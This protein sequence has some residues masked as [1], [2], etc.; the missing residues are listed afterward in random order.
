M[1][2]PAPLY[3]MPTVTD[4][5]DINIHDTIIENE[6]T[7]TATA[8]YNQI[9]RTITTFLLPL[10]LQPTVGFG[11]SKNV[12]PH[13]PIYHQL[14][15]SSHFQLLKISFYFLFPS[16]PGPSPSSR[17]FQFLSEDLFGHPI[18]LHSLQMTL[19]T[20][21]FPVIHF[22]VFYSSSSRFVLLFHSPFSYLA[23]YILL[24]IFV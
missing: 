6:I 19:S 1:L 10:A 4:N 17:P 24:N 8:I 20:Y 5:K 15:P 16:F 11:L 2:L 21:P 12:L 23:P 18:L 7:T 22:T 14:S 13:F 3:T 9:I